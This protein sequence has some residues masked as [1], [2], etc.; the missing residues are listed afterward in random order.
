MSAPRNSHV[1]VRGSQLLFLHTQYLR[2]L[3]VRFLRMKRAINE[4]YRQRAALSEPPSGHITGFD[5]SQL[6]PLK[7]P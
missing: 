5:V 6:Q 7:G 3:G 4:R 1:S 2:C